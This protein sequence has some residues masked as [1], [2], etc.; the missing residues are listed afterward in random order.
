MADHSDRPHT[1]L[2]VASYR[3]DLATVTRLLGSG[4]DY[5]E[6]DASGRTALHWAVTKH[7]IKVVENLLAHHQHA[8]S[9]LSKVPAHDYSKF[10]YRISKILPVTKLL[11][12]KLQSSLFLTPA[13]PSALTYDQLQRLAS[14]VRPVITPIELAAQVGDEAIFKLLLENLEP[15]AD[16]AVLLNGV[17]P[18][19]SP[20]AVQSLRMD[21]SGFERVSNEKLPSKQYVNEL[22]WWKELTGFILHVAIQDH[23]LAVAEMVLRL[24]ADV[25]AVYGTRTFRPLHVAASCQPDPTFIRVLLKYGADPNSESIWGSRTPLSVAIGAYNEGAVSELLRA[26]ASPKAYGNRGNDDHLRDTCSLLGE[27]PAPDPAFLLR[28]LRALLEAGADPNTGSCLAYIAGRKNGAPLLVELA[29]WGANIT[30]LYMAGFLPRRSAHD[31]NATLEFLTAYGTPS[32]L[33]DVILWRGRPR[34]SYP[35]LLD[36]GLNADYPPDHWTFDQNVKECTGDLLPVHFGMLMESAHNVDRLSTNHK[37]WLDSLFINH[38][39]N[40]NVTVDTAGRAL[41]VIRVLDHTGDIDPD[42]AAEILFG[43]VQDYRG[44]EIESV[45]DALLDLGAG[46]YHPRRSVIPGRLPRYFHDI[47]AL[48]AIYGHETILSC[49]LRRLS[50]QAE[51]R[52][53]SFLTWPSWYQEDEFNSTRLAHGGD[54]V[55]AALA[56]LRSSR[57]L[58]KANLVHTECPL[59]VTVKRRDAEAVRKLVSYG[60]DVNRQ[61]E[62]QWTL[63]HTAIEEGCTEIVDILLQADASK[64]I[65]VRARH[66]PV[67]PTHSNT[68]DIYRIFSSEGI[69]VRYVSP[70]HLAAFKGKP[71]IVRS[72]LAHGADVHAATDSDGPLIPGSSSTRATALD[73]ALFASDFKGCN[74]RDNKRGRRRSLW[75]LGRV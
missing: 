1:A 73:F 28:T 21:M 19:V 33:R 27:R 9:S 53:A 17:W 56:C 66:L 14:R 43:V 25:E 74:G 5:L 24:G 4:K 75:L 2:S 51:G 10:T 68:R 65:N 32:Y 59:V 16:T 3:G 71:S 36:F 18:P 50:A 69:H 6:A 60:L 41:G 7:H 11:G 54:N 39:Q 46:L 44:G 70:L 12:T 55:D 23:K 64:S 38:L 58:L 26:G 20:E 52:E 34:I 31:Y 35:V 49:L 42:T 48:S 57:Y 8:I 40:T 45:V 37:S 29:A 47:V 72:L 63:V 15:F 30:P 67:A 13:Q 61:D 62:S 22:D